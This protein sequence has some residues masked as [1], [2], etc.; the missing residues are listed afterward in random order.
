VNPASGNSGLANGG[1]DA[2][3]PGGSRPGRTNSPPR[4]CQGRGHAPGRDR[5]R[6]DPSLAGEA[7]VMSHADVI[8]AASVNMQEVLSA[9]WPCLGSAVQYFRPGLSY[10]GGAR[11]QGGSGTLRP[12]VL[13]GPRRQETAVRPRGDRSPSHA[14]NCRREW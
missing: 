14:D 6:G 4:P 3:T 2:D 1:L 11:C 10:P 5:Q 13:S 7:A 12:P 8:R 9:Y